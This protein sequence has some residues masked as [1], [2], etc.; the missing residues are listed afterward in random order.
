VHRIA[1]IEDNADIR[2]LLHEALTDE[3][4]DALSI[5]EPNDL[6]AQLTAARP[7]LV[8]IDLRLGKWGDGLALASSI[9]MDPAYRDIPLTVMSA[10]PEDLRRN[11]RTLTNLRCRVIEKPFDLDDLFALIE[12][13]LDSAQN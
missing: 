7:D 11:K 13:E 1:I 8:L 12:G 5:E 10:A 2:H 6:Q 9:R 3:G 4:Y